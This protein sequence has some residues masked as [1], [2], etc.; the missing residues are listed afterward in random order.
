MSELLASSIEPL[1][2]NPDRYLELT[3]R[4]YNDPHEDIKDDYRQLLKDSELQLQSDVATL[5]TQLPVSFEGLLSEDAFTAA[6]HM[7]HWEEHGFANGGFGRPRT[8]HETQIIGQEANDYLRAKIKETAEA[9]EWKA[10]FKNRDYGFLGTMMPG[11]LTWR[12]EQATYIFDGEHFALIAPTLFQMEDGSVL[13]DSHLMNGLGP[14]H[15]RKHAEV[16]TVLPVDGD[17]IDD[18]PLR[19][20][21]FN[22]RSGIPEGLPTEKELAFLERVLAAYY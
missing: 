6:W 5:R 9:H 14:S 7:A 22:L 19:K 11:D 8:G 15:L 16:R 21:P 12:M 17:V 2:Y 3:H 13:G 1:P 18:H 20:N 10:F 4:I